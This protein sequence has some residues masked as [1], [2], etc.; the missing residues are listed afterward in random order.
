MVLTDV[1]ISAQ[2]SEFPTKPTHL[3]FHR[4]NTVTQVA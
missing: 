3:R 1:I 2:V 4:G